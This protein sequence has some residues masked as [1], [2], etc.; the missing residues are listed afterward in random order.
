MKRGCNV[1]NAL[2]PENEPVI[3]VFSGSQ[4]KSSQNKWLWLFG[5][6]LFV[7]RS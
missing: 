1:P 3:F 5:D 2:I 6:L 4:S 7:L